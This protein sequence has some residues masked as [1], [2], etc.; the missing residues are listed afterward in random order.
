MISDS[1]KTAQTLLIVCGFVACQ[2][3][4]VKALEETLKKK[5]NVSEEPEL[6][7]ALGAALLALRRLEKLR[8]DKESPLIGEEA[9]ATS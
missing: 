1:A 9:R 5:V 4:I 7:G 8:V 2:K 6:I 3:G